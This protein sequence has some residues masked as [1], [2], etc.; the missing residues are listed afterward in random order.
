MRER[1]DCAVFGTACTEGWTA[2]LVGAHAGGRLHVHTPWPGAQASD[3]AAAQLLARS[4]MQLRRFDVCLMPATEAN[5]A[6]VRTSLLA[7]GG[8]LS[9]P[10]IALVRQLRATALNDLYALGVADIIRD[11]LCIEELRVRIERLLDQGRGIADVKGSG[12]EPPIVLGLPPSYGGSPSSLGE[13]TG[14]YTEKVVCSGS[15]PHAQTEADLCS[16]ILERTGL[17]LDAYAA[18]SASRCATSRES[19]RVAKGKII[20][21][22]ERAYIK[23]ALGRHSGNIAMAARSAQKHR[24]AF[25]ALMRKYQIDAAPYRAE[26]AS[27]PSADR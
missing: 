22:F 5:L 25:W 21:R 18:A 20:E 4:T 6:W 27:K 8:K 10:V 15:G 11:P 14:S 24:R 17:E 16:S 2:G 12:A 23:A 1:L 26:A 13:S 9:T 7:A 19:F 3:P